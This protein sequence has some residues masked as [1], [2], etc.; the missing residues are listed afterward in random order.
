MGFWL[1]SSV[2]MATK[3]LEWEELASLGSELRFLVFV[4][5]PAPKVCRK[6]EK[7]WEIDTCIG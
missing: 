3:Q 6:K 1:I 2:K 4:G 5:T 7:T